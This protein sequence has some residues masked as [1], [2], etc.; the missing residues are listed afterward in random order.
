MRRQV[1]DH[2][3]LHATADDAHVFLA[4]DLQVEQR[5]QEATVLQALQQDVEG[6]LDRLRVC[7]A[8]VNDTGHLA[9]AASLAGGPLACPRACLGDKI[10]NLTSHCNS[11][12]LTGRLQGCRPR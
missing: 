4:L 10:W 9:F 5:R 8:A 1:L 12:C 6:D 3:A 11:P 7:A 2:V